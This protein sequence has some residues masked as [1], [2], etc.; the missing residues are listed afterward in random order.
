MRKIFLG[1]LILCIS[2]CLVFDIALASKEKVDQADSNGNVLVK[3][4]ILTGFVLTDKKIFEQII[5][6]NKNK[7][8]SQEQ[9]QTIVDNVR[10]IYLA[11]GYTDLVTVS[12]KLD[13]NRLVINI[14]LLN[15]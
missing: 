1:L 5:K 9:I 8:L 13:K 3:R 10:T 2:N 14:L 12:Y 15:R 4:V 11:N 6:E 7:R